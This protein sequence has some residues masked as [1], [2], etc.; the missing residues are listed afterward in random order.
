MISVR[1]LAIILCKKI[2]KT[3]AQ[4]YLLHKYDWTRYFSW[5]TNNASKETYVITERVIS[6]NELLRG[7]HKNSVTTHMK[8]NMWQK[9]NGEVNVVGSYLRSVSEE[10]N[11]Y[12]NLK[13]FPFSKG[14]WRGSAQVEEMTI[15]NFRNTASFSGV[16]GGYETYIVISGEFTVILELQTFTAWITIA[17]G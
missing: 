14:S 10:R 16:E 17:F 12:C 4:N 13:N 2:W 15:N 11:K 7:R 3:Y 9:I 6:V 5:C 8:N 1:F